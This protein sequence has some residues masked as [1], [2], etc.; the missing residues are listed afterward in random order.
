LPSSS[1]AAWPNPQVQFLHG[2]GELLLKFNLHG[3][4]LRARVDTPSLAA[5]LREA[6]GPFEVDDDAAPDFVLTIQ[7][8]QEP[9]ADVAPEGMQEHWRGTLPD[10]PPVVCYRGASEREVLLP[11]LARLRLTERG[12]D[13]RAV[14]GADGWLNLGCLLP[15]LCEFLARRGH[16]VVHAATLCTHVAGAPRALVVGGP[17][18]V[19]KTTTA[20]ALA[21]AG[22]QLLTDDATFLTLPGPGFDAFRV[23]GLPRPC[24]VHRRT[25]E[26]MP[27]LRPLCDGAE[28]V[29][30]EYLVGWAALAG[31][32]V[33]GL[34][35]PAAVLLL[36]PR[37]PQA[38]RLRPLDRVEAVARLINENVRAGDPRAEGP[39]GG[40][41]R[42]LAALAARVPVCALSVGPELESL[43]PVVRPLLAPSR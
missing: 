14:P 21:H 32:G 6:V 24:K 27:W 13:I 40:A 2:E 43:A 37:N 34:A 19:G 11:G 35:E 3:V 41:F 30:D 33:P 39:A 29:A 18:G 9:F 10:G 23:W 17:S 15:A 25:V 1:P 31:P 42:A 12:G 26:L 38:H 7:H 4:R 8:A 16:Y 5:R 28:P 36:E 20:L 22:M